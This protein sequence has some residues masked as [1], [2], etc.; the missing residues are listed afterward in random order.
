MCSI[1]HLHYS[2][3]RKCEVY[4][5]LIWNSIRL[6]PS[7][8]LLA[9][10]TYTFPFLFT[11]KFILMKYK[12]W[13]SF[14]CLPFIYVTRGSPDSWLPYQYLLLTLEIWVK[15]SE[16]YRIRDE[17]KFIVQ[18]SFITAQ[19]TFKDVLIGERSWL[20]QAS[21]ATIFTDQVEGKNGL[22]MWLDRLEIIELC[23]QRTGTGLQRVPWSPERKECS[24]TGYPPPSSHR[25][26]ISSLYSWDLRT[27]VKFI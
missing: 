16:G 27:W 15:L 25:S 11:Y 4:W 6:L 9:F 20:V 26:T 7:Q 23:P 21:D 17:H 13:I 5:E 22:C 3:K 18:D 1:S 8:T 2:A 24:H 14:E 12:V 10:P 19:L